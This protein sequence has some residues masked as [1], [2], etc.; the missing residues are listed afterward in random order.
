MGRK[1]E[2]EREISYCRKI[3]SE[4]RENF[5]VAKRVA[6]MFFI[7]FHHMG[8]RADDNTHKRFRNWVRMTE[9]YNERERERVC[10]RGLV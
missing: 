2:R 9:L 8:D 4:E 5:L 1:G 3:S 7:P 10:I 6:N